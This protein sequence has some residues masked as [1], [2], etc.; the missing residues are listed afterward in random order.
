MMTTEQQRALAADPDGLATY[1]F[2]ANNIEVLTQEDIELLASNM[3][4]VDVSG[5]FCTSA[6][7]YLNAIDSQAYASPVRR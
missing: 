5:Q 3:I 2:I 6:A 1:E 7:R 4:Q